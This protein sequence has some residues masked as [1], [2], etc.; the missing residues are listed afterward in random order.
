M[1]IDSVTFFTS[2]LVGIRDNQSAMARLN[3]QIATGQNF[4]APKDDPLATQKVLDLGNR[5]AARTQYA[6][7]QTKADLAL[8]YESTVLNE[9]ESAL[10]KARALL[11]GTSPAFDAQARDAHAQQLRGVFEHLLSL[12]NTQDPSGN[13]IFAGDKTTT[14]PFANAGGGDGGNPPAGVVTGY[15]GS[16]STREV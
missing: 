13:Y 15:V 14:Q 9:V 7:N 12:A 3:E 8:E 10:N 4:L 16:A 1:R 11:V 5:L 2:G 6:A